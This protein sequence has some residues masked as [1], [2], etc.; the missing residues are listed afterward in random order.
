[1]GSAA[2][3]AGSGMTTA[4]CAGGAGAAATGATGFGMATGAGPLAR[5]VGTAEGDVAGDAGGT[6]AIGPGSGA[7]GGTVRRGP[8][9]GRPTASRYFAM[10]ASRAAG[11]AVY[12]GSPVMTSSRP[13]CASVAVA[14]DP[15]GSICT[16]RTSHRRS[17]A[18]SGTRS[19][20][21]VRSVHRPMTS[22]IVR[23]SSRCSGRPT[24]SA[25]ATTPICITS[26]RWSSLG[27]PAPGGMAIRM[28]RHSR[29]RDRR[30]WS[31]ADPNT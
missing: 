4:A 6:T 14:K 20:F 21:T 29:S 10:N 22:V 11:A 1:M 15:R 13:C 23:S 27:L 7:S 26:L 12:E 31:I 9:E 19:P 3:A 18:L 25:S 17:G 2:G 16:V 24:R 8:S 28:S 30:S 5:E